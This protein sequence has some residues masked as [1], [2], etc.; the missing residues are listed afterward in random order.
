MPKNLVLTSPE[1]AFLKVSLLTRVGSPEPTQIRKV[2]RLGL[3][4]AAAALSVFWYSST[5]SLVLA[6]TSDTFFP[7]T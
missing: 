4:G 3:A 1:L 6:P 2:S 7:N 5:Q